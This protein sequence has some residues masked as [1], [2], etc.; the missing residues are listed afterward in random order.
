MIVHINDLHIKNKQPYLDANRELFKWLIDNYKNETLII[1]GDLWDTSSPFAEN[2]AEFIG[3]IKQF[4]SVIINLGNHDTSRRAGNSLL[5]LKHHSNI[6]V[7][8]DKTDLELE[9]NKCLFLP[10]IYNMKEEYDNIE[11]TGDY[12]FIHG[13]NI[14]DSFGDSGLTLS[15]IKAKQIFSHIHIKKEYGNKYVPGVANPS[16]NGEF[17]NPILIINNGN[18]EWANHPV[19]FEF[20]TIE[21]GKF[22]ENKNNILNIKKAPSYQ[23]VYDMYKD[24]YV[25]KE[26]IEILR[27]ENDATI[28][29][30]E[31][32]SGNIID[33]FARYAKEKEVSKEIFECANQYLQEVI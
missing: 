2:E 18:I 25:R 13:E 8:I 9:G 26:G 17:N 7:I 28:V 23:S 12:C 16:R 5:H 3:Y 31:F 15:K 19:Y 6:Q 1:G 10:F 11:W 29:D 22:P 24:Y 20:E 30:K 33:R 14:E 4:K 21:Y 27:T 32:E